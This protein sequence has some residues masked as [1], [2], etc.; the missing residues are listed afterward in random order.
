MKYHGRPEQRTGQSEPRTDIG[1]NRSSAN[2]I[3][4]HAGK[5][6]PSKR[7]VSPRMAHDAN[8]NQGYASK[9]A[10]RKRLCRRLGNPQ[11][12]LEGKRRKNQ[13]TKSG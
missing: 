5:H 4:E 10:D 12:S 8:C 7:A 9:P 13:Q 1:E 3:D 2:I 11:Q 6:P